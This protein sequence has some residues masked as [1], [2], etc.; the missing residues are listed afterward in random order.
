V[1]GGRGARDLIGRRERRSGRQMLGGS[2]S[3]RDGGKRSTRRGECSG[4]RF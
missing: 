2:M 4:K 3:I 1:E